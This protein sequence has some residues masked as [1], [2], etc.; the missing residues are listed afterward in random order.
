MLLLSPYPTT[1]SVWNVLQ[2]ITCSLMA[3][4]PSFKHKTPTLEKNLKA[5]HSGAQERLPCVYKPGRRSWDICRYILLWLQ[6]PSRGSRYI[7]GQCSRPPD[8]ATD[9]EMHWRSKVSRS[10][11][12]RP[13]AALCLRTALYSLYCSDSS[14]FPI[15]SVFSLSSFQSSVFLSLSLPTLPHLKIQICAHW[16]QI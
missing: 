7:A 12:R 6:P 4:A 1:P 15:Y 3:L 5:D 11:D 14:S 2:P 10:E 9:A 8:V 16:T 13:T